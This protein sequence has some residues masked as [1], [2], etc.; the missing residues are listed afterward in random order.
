MPSVRDVRSFHRDETGFVAVPA[1]DNFATARSSH[2]A[3]FV[4]LAAEIYP[5]DVEPIHVAK[6]KQCFGDEQEAHYSRLAQ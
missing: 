6:Y 1:F 4:A 2:K 3:P 5:R